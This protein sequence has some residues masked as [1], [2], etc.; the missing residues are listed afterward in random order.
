MVIYHYVERICRIIVTPNFSYKLYNNENCYPG[1]PVNIYTIIDKYYL[2]E[3]LGNYNHKRVRVNYHYFV[4]MENGWFSSTAWDTDG[5][6]DWLMQSIRK[7]VLLTTSFLTDLSYNNPIQESS[8]FTYIYIFGPEAKIIFFYFPFLSWSTG[9]SL[10]FTGS[11]IY[12]ESEGKY[13]LLTPNTS[14]WDPHTTMY[15]DQEHAMVE[16]KGHI[17]ENGDTWSKSDQRISAVINRS[18]LNIVSDPILFEFSVSSLAPGEMNASDIKSKTRRGGVSTKE[19]ADQLNIP[20]YMAQKTIQ[21][22]TQFSVRTVKKPSLTTKFRTNYRM[23]WCARLA[24]NTLMDTFLSSNKSGSSAK[25]YTPCQ[26]FAAEFGHVFLVTM[27]GKSVIN[28][29][30]AIKKYFKEIDAPLYIIC[31]Q[32]LSL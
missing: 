6:M 27:E 16:Y 23:L 26:V 22:T 11:T 17:K 12:K 14:E 28:I 13:M 9:W 4:V 31:D 20:Y 1:E 25:G 21:A 30:K 29:S 10:L 7:L 19:L 3:Q 5:L 24:Y 15:R 2:E 18:A 32:A 8:I